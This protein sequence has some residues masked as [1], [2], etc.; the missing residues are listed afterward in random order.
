MATSISDLLTMVRRQ[1]LET[2]ARFWTDAELI[3]LMNL[4]VHDLWGSINDEYQG[5]FV[6]L[7]TTHVRM[8]ASGSQL[9][10]VPPDVFRVELLE[11][12]D[13]T[14]QSA[15]LGLIFQPRDYRHPDF[16]SARANDA[17]DPSNTTIFYALF[18]EGAPVNAP[19]IRVAPRINA[20]INL[21]LLYVPTLPK[22]TSS[23]TNPV[24]GESDAALVAWTIA[25][26]RAKET[27]ERAPDAAWLTIY[28]TEKQNLL[29]RLTP[30]Q[31]QD[32][33]TADAIFQPYW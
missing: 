11:P 16:V 29:V 9:D 23:G 22:I 32:P 24:P 18:N 30:R 20:A 5:H 15:N 1:L 7:D 2:T 25:W 8:P 13:L 33:E 17:V 27:E 3:D 19:T 28:K 4:G 26:A 21:T 31:T 14:S 6:T 12:R 10:G